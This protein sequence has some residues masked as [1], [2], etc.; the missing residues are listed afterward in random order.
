MRKRLLLRLC[1]CMVFIAASHQVFS[2]TKK[3]TGTVVSDSTGEGLEAVSVVVTGTKIGTSTDA[4]GH[5][6]IDVPAKAHS[7][8]FSAIGYKTLKTNVLVGGGWNDNLNIRLKT[9]T[10][11]LDELVVIAYGRSKKEAITGSVSQITSKDIEKRAQTT[12]TGVLEGSSPGIMVNNTYG[13]PGST[14]S[15]RIRGISSI[16]GENSPLYVVDGVIFS[17]SLADINPNDVESVSVLKDAASASLY[18]N[19]AANGVVIVTTKKGKNGSLSLTAVANQG[20]YNRGIPEYDRMNANQFMET[21]WTGYKHALLSTANSTYTEATAAAQASSGLVD[22]YLAYNIYNKANDELFDANGKLVSDAQIRSGYAGDMD[23]YSPILQNGHR[24]DYTVSGAARTD[25]S[26]MFFSAGY[27][28]EKGYFKRS[29]FKRFTGRIS[30]DITPRKWIKAGFSLNGTHQISGNYSDGNSSFV[31]PIFYARTIAPIYPVHLHDMTTGDYIL[32]ASGNKQYDDGQTYGRTQYL[33]RHAI[34]ENELNS[35]NTY[36]NTLQGQGYVDIKFLKDFTFT[37]KGDLNVWNQEQQT[38]DNATIGDGAG[39]NGRASRNIYRYKIYTFQQQLNW[40]KYFGDHSVNVLAGHENYSYYRSYLY[41]YKTTETFAGMTDLINFTNITSLYDYQDRYKTESYLSRVRYNYKEKYFFDASIRRDASSRFS[42]GARWGT[43]WSV[44]ASWS[45]MKEDF[46]ASLQDKINNLRLKASYGGIGNDQSADRYAYW[47]LYDI[48]QNANVAALYKSQLAAPGLQWETQGAS[49]FGLEGRFFNRVNLAI[50]YFHKKSGNQ[51]FNLYL[52]LSAGA[53]SSSSAEATIATNIGDVVNKGWEFSVDVDAV[54]FNNFRWNI[55]VMATVQKN[56]VTKLADQ[57]K[58]NG[59]INGSKKIFEG[60]GIYDYWMYQ[61]VGVDQMT[62]NSLFK[63]DDVTYNGGDD[64]VTDGRAA[65]PSTWLVDVNGTKYVTNPTYAKRDWSGSAFPKV[66]GSFNTTLTWKSLTLYALFT[67]SFGNKVIDYNYASLMS[68]GGTPSALHTDLLNA[69][70]GVPSGITETS[71]DRI[72][73][74]GVPIVDFN[75]SQYNNN[76]L[77][78][79]FLQ[80]GK[81]FVIKN[82]SLNYKM[83]RSILDR[84]DVN[85]VAFTFTVENL[86]TFTTKKGM[87]PQ[88]SFDGTNYNYFM[89]PR[90]FSLGVTVGL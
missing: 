66:I 82:L 85:S 23:W 77:S 78:S 30:G 39:N 43:F 14:P 15:I 27:L 18:G 25:K 75:L 11:D 56:I 20:I 28:D 74:N 61:Y 45:I 46:M 5:F 64:N 8:T 84:L 1:V 2:Q 59:I 83:P 47:A 44:G 65:I 24:Q 50:D 88:Q 12:V 68:M 3:I 80:D 60:H 38:Y 70:N 29:N 87:N 76:T 31:N 86:K 49:N 34:W 40:D 41:G 81:Y 37:T 33:G 22:N 16:N 4:E 51:I 32:D 42:S 69:W 52:P 79:R 53:T 13:Q 62:G 72:D 7:L 55:G 67:Y 89:T 90:V 73:P 71:A 9:S 19:R 48:N 54:R 17:G 10:S 63:P 58:E 26:G 21:M 35:N 36:K 57:F 6:S